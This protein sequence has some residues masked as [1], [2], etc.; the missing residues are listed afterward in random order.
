MRC[1]GHRRTIGR[2]VGSKMV[3]GGLGS[4]GKM[5]S[6]ADG[7]CA[8]RVA[9]KPHRRSEHPQSSPCHG[10]I[11]SCDIRESWRL[12]RL[13]RAFGRE[14]RR[15]S[16]PRERAR[17]IGARSECL[18]RDAQSVCSTITARSAINPHVLAINAC[19]EASLQCVC[20]PS[21]AQR[22]ALRRRRAMIRS[23]RSSPC[24]PA[25]ARNDLEHRACTLGPTRHAAARH[26]RW[27]RCRQQAFER[28]I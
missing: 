7:D 9:P 14:T 8:A 28:S 26:R 25:T 6:T 5:M 10:R 27:S 20:A 24:M 16:E 12:H 3:T 1:P 11:G 22:A 13:C 4:S 17:T 23:R 21:S 18:A 2:S 15:A 19:A